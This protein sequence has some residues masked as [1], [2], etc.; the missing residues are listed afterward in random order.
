MLRVQ[1]LIFL[2]RFSIFGLILCLHI[3]IFDLQLCRIGIGWDRW[4]AADLPAWDNI[5]YCECNF[6]SF[7][8]VFRFMDR[9]FVCALEF[10]IFNFVGSEL[11]ETDGGMADLRVWDNIGCWQCNLSSFWGVFRFMDWVMFAHGNFWFLTLSDRNWLKP[12]EVWQICV[13]GIILD[14]ASAIFNIFEAFFDLWI[15]F[16]FAH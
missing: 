15:G 2:R 9:V 13:L 16:M 3:A 6:S 10:L 4:G 12:M 14:A 1:S 7:W 11:A 5:G 8:G